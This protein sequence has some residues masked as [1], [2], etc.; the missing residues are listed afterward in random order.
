MLKVLVTGANGFVGQVLI[1]ALEN[2]NI[3]YSGAVRYAN[4]NSKNGFIEVGDID[5]KTDWSRALEDVDV[6]I[7]L[8]ARVHVMN[9]PSDDPLAAFTNVNVDGLRN[10]ALQA[11]KA[12]V[13]RFVFVSSVKVNGE[14]TNKQP[15]TENDVPN[16]QDPYAISKWEAEKALRKIEKETGME[17][18]ILR[19]PLVYGAGVKANFASLLKLVNKKLPLPLASINAK[20]SLI[21]VDN[22]VD[23]IIVCASHPKAA[24]QT[25][26]VSDGED[27]S[28]PQLINKI[29]NAL[30]KPSYL[31]PFPVSIMRLLAKLTCKSASVDRLTQSLMIDS[32]KIHQE[33]DWRPPFTME[34]GLKVTA[35]WYRKSLENERV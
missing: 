17:V 12:N 24:G 29:A 1:S 13:K 5:G 9:E 6:V 34:Q 2:R 16:P 22:L 11:A 32:S 21:Y 15:F 7:H 31:L 19:P 26:L 10:L 23:A 27:A 8:A 18:V 28:M 14:F 35:D 3:K 30:N 33:L 25:Y 20:R 4:K